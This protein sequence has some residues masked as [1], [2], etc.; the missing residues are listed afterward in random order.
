MA[1]INLFSRKIQSDARAPAQEIGEDVADL[2]QSPA[3]N[4]LRRLDGNGGEK[5]GGQRK[6]RGKMEREQDPP[7]NE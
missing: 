5:D 4:V 3:G 2:E 6:R 7:G 1:Q